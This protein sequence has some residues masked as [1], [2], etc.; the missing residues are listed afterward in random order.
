MPWNLAEQFDKT[1]STDYQ[2]RV[3]Q[4]FLKC[5]FDVTNEDAGTANH[6]NRLKLAEQ[7][8]SGSGVPPRAFQLL[9]ILNPALQV[10]SGD[11]TD[12][13]LLFTVAGQ[14]DRFSPQAP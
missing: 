2:K 6:A 5:A 7:V 14:W 1:A 11:P 13:D 10:E 8:I 4:A 9:P 3:A 12:N